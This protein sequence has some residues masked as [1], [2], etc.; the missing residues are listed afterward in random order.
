MEPSDFMEE[1]QMEYLELAS[2]YVSGMLFPPSRLDIGHLGLAFG[3]GLVIG[4]YLASFIG[5]LILLFVTM[6]NG[7]KFKYFRTLFFDISD[8]SGKI[9]FTIRKFTPI[10]QCQTIKTD[11]TDKEDKM[12]SV[13]HIAIMWAVSILIFVTTLFCVQGHIDDFYE[14]TIYNFFMGMASA[15]M[16]DN[17]FITFLTI[18]AHVNAK[19][20]LRG[21]LKQIVKAWINGKRLE[22]MELPSHEQLSLKT[23]KYDLLLYEN[24]RFMQK[25]SLGLY[26]ELLPIVEFLEGN[27]T[28]GYIRSETPTYY[29]IIFY[30]SYINRNAEKAVSYFGEAEDDLKHDMDSNGR[31]VMAYYEYYILGQKES[32][33]KTAMDGLKVID[34]FS[35][36]DEERK[37][38]RKLLEYILYE[39]E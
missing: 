4:L 2:E 24:L 29:T 5:A 27:L 21:W 10:S 6:I 14:D 33:I 26:S 37:L 23:T 30:Y 3:F 7:F 18:S 15:V 38:E 8:V 12:I 34:K 9:T 17:V 39:A 32:A 35:I 22:D 28:K 1:L 36:C 25:L 20:S 19:K 31:R 11:L 16:I 13:M